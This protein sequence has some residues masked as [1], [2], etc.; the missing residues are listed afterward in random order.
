MSSAQ[1][2]FT[3]RL[4]GGL[5]DLAPGVDPATVLAA[6]ASE[7]TKFFTP[8]QVV[9]IVEA[10]MRGLRIPFGIAIGCACATFLL[11]FLPRYQTIQIKL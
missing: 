6:G 2:G 11:A 4:L 7:L 8:E 3:N 9:G 5:P 10:Y 1:A